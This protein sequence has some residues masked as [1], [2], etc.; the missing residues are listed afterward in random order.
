VKSVLS[1][2]YL[3]IF[4]LQFCFSCMMEQKDLATSDLVFEDN[5][6]QPK[7]APSAND[8]NDKG[9]GPDTSVLQVEAFED[10]LHPVLRGASCV[11]CHGAGQSPQF[12]TASS[13]E[14]WD[15]L[16]GTGK[17]DLEDPDQS[18]IV[19][20][21]VDQSHNC[22][23]DCQ[24]VSNEILAAVQNL[25]DD[26]R[27]VASAVSGL[28]T[29][30]SKIRDGVVE[31]AQTE[32]GRLILS[33]S[34]TYVGVLNG[35]Y[36][37]FLD[38]K[39]IG[40]FYIDGGSIPSNPIT[41]AN[42]TLSLN[43]NGCEYPSAS[44]INNYTSGAVRVDE[45]ATH[46]NSGDRTSPVT[47]SVVKDGYE[48]FSYELRAYLIR[49]DKRLEFAKALLNGDHLSV[50]TYALTDGDFASVATKRAGVKAPALVDADNEVV[51]NAFRYLP[52]F[53]K[54][55]EVFNTN[56]SFK[57]AGNM[58]SKDDGSMANVYELFKEGSY[59]PP[60]EK[61][62]DILREP[63]KEHLKLKLIYPKL[64]SATKSLIDANNEQYVRGVERMG[65][66]ALLA[67]NPITIEL[68]CPDG[69]VASELF[70]SSDPDSRYKSCDP[71]NSQYPGAY[72]DLT[73]KVTTS[74]SAFE[75]LTYS[76]ALQKMTVD[77]D[78]IEPA[79]ATDISNG[80]WFH[81]I[82]LFSYYFSNGAGNRFGVNDFERR[83]MVG[84]SGSFNS[85]ET[86]SAD[87]VNY[88]NNG[89]VRYDL[90]KGGQPLDTSGIYAGAVTDIDDLIMLEHF[91]NT[92]YPELQDSRCIECHSSGNQP[93]F[94]HTNASLALQVLQEEGFINFRDPGDS[95]RG[96]DDGV[97]HNCNNNNPDPRFDCSKDNELR[98][99]FVDAIRTWR[100]ENESVA[101]GDGVLSL[102]ERQR[103]PGVAKYE[104]KINEEGYYNVWMRISTADGNNKRINY[105]ILDSNGNPTM[106]YSAN[107]GVPQSRGE[108]CESFNFDGN[109]WVWTTEGRLTERETLDDIGR[110]LLDQ[111]QE[112]IPLPDER[113]YWN[114][115]PGMY[116]L[117]VFEQTPG[118]QLNL[119]A[120]NK[121]DN[122][123]DKGRLNFQPDLIQAD[124]KYISN[125]KRRI[126]KYDL[127][128][129]V[130]IEADEEA[131]F[132]IEARET[133]NGQAYTFNGPRFVYN[134]PDGKKLRVKDIKGLVNEKFEFT[135]S[136]FTK[137]DYTVGKGRV[138]TYSPL[139]TLAPNPED[140]END[141]FSFSFDEISVV[142][143]GDYSE[144]NPNGVPPALSTGRSCLELDLFVKT[145]KPI[146]KDVRVV[147]EEDLDEFIDDAPGGASDPNNAM[148]TYRCMTCHT[149]NHPYFKMTTF[150]FNDDLLCRQALSRVDFSNFYQST[151]VRGINGSNNHPKFFFLEKFFYEDSSKKAW[152]THDQANDYIREFN[153][154]PAGLKSQF[155]RGP[156]PVFDRSDFGFSSGT[157]YNSL[158]ESNKNKA[159]MIGSF[160]GI[161]Y[162]QIPNDPGQIGGYKDLLHYDILGEIR[163]ER[164]IIDPNHV[165]N[166]GPDGE[167]ERTDPIYVNRRNAGNAMYYKT[168]SGGYQPRPHGMN[169]RNLTGL[170]VNYQKDAQNHVINTVD[171]R[172]DLSGVQ[173][174]SE[175]IS[176]FEKLR[177]RYREAVIDWVRAEDKA[178]KEQN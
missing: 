116:T 34:Q 140:K 135:D 72:Y 52:H 169:G 176:E 18:R 108:S 55:D 5:S 80:N 97:V 90:D 103:T 77:G 159:K 91:E 174:K 63:D 58:Y 150:D 168:S 88:P 170:I 76:N 104:F 61:L 95:F 154:H 125:Y 17:V 129:L 70:D 127:S 156:F 130:D 8:T 10:H 49:P 26:P 27:M 151:I 33:A 114:L 164:D 167:R 43:V 69:W 29:K 4:I 81:R 12:A 136:T 137:L 35:R 66:A 146:L 83:Y 133:D 172:D 109:S 75:P 19:R 56:G 171:Y 62:Y 71:T 51:Y 54:Y 101:S 153:R 121:V 163:G 41:Q 46:I 53:A 148:G 60:P 142:S 110:Q 3:I 105:R 1:R 106:T 85:N 20:K 36:E 112:T 73:Y 82:D 74:P 21:V 78:R 39:A 94:A 92:L 98:N 31:P 13:K 113:V 161:Q 28:Q 178:Y 157:N 131:Y 57:S 89:V 11:S 38:S 64:K 152:D 67:T 47:G 175:V 59:E 100:D 40:Q 2:T 44:Q 120:I 22:G 123:S 143:E 48:P 160:K 165:P 6:G 162:L 65:H 45:T 139:V 149:E 166:I 117:E 9:S 122:F 7:R 126:L 50:P 102:S 111:E 37:N 68:A 96:R 147:L 87:T 118:A 84:Q 14:S 134:N 177:T 86:F 32:Y 107:S 145:V 99:K 25:S 93:R 115:N 42:R 155:V 144:I 119:F 132:Q 124:E 79:T 158:S 138:M 30:T 128:H 173:G 23:G 15:N 24:S 16:Y 141:F